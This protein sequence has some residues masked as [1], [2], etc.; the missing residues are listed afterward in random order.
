LAN[1][2]E[3]LAKPQ[4]FMKQLNNVLRL[5]YRIGLSKPFERRMMVITTVGSHSGKKVPAVV[6]YLKKDDKIYAFS[7]Y[8]GSDWLHNIQ[9]NSHVEIQIGK[10]KM[11]TNARVVEDT[12]EKAEAFQAFIDKSSKRV[13]ER[14]YQVKP[15]MHIEEIRSIA[16]QTPTIRFD[17]EK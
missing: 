17:P 4:G 3:L 14:F 10:E 8:K 11:K 9:K 6:A 5:F 7:V 12:E 13:A 1:K 16:I 15:D 2:I